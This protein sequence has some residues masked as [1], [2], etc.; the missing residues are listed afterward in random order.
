[1]YWFVVLDS[2]AQSRLLSILC[3]GLLCFVLHLE[4]ARQTM[5]DLER[6][7]ILKH[8]SDDDKNKKEERVSVSPFGSW[9]DPRSILKVDELPIKEPVILEREDVQNNED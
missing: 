1:M 3:V 9:V 8:Y 7:L 5:N 6:E 4:D 2:L